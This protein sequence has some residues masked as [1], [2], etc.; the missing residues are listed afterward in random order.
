MTEFFI[1]L[2]HLQK[3]AY[4][5]TYICISESNKAYIV[6][7][8]IQNISRKD[9]TYYLNDFISNI[10]DGYYGY[11]SNHIWIRRDYIYG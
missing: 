6:I 5:K 9:I 3:D 4:Y 1:L 10:S 2:S 7:S 8:N 11:G